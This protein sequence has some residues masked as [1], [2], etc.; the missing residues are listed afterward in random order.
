MVNYRVLSKTRISRNQI[1]DRKMAVSHHLNVN[2]ELF[3]KVTRSLHQERA[4]SEHE[5]LV[6]GGYEN[7]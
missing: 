6:R 3:N 1:I 2:N 5:K 7:L 4:I